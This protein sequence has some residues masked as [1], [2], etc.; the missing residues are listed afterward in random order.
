MICS[1]PND[2]DGLTRDGDV[3]K[4]AAGLSTVSLDGQTRRI[5]LWVEPKT[6][7]YKSDDQS[8]T[9]TSNANYM[10]QYMADVCVWSRT[11]IERSYK[12]NVTKSRNTGFPGERPGSTTASAG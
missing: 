9:A 12:F 4:N 3:A 8:L 7:G 1:N 2:T 11:W 10:K 5:E 6:S